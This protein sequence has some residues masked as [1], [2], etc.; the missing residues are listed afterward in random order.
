MKILAKTI[1][2]GL[3]FVTICCTNKHS[4]ISS[5]VKSW[6]NRK[7]NYPKQMHFNNANDEVV[8]LDYS[9]RYKV[10]CYIDSAG[11]TSCKLKNQLFRWVQ[12]MN[13]VDN[14]TDYSTAFIFAIQSNNKEQIQRLLIDYN[15]SYPVFFDTK[16]ELKSI[17]KLPEQEELCCF[18]LDRND[19]VVLMGNPIYGE[20]MQKLFL[21]TLANVNGIDLNCKYQTNTPITIN[22][23]TFKV[24]D[25]QNADYYL[26]NTSP[27]DIHIR[28]IK[29]S[30]DCTSTY[31]DKDIISP[32]DSAHIAITLKME[33]PESFIRE[34]YVDVIDREPIVITIEGIAVD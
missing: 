19:N 33:K 14:L 23:G 25:I 7:I 16:G 26:I 1:L 22:I 27:V 9:G 17:N 28:S 8:P 29:S 18:L 30:C 12:F 31:I 6:E 10:L 34:I 11:C 24:A 15:F 5:I 13:L 3:S 20:K 21:E 4:D 32:K 2:L